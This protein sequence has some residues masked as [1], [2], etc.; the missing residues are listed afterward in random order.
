MNRPSQNSNRIAIIGTIPPPFGGVSIHI[1]R[2]LALLERANIGFTVY[3]QSCKDD[4]N[5]NIVPFKPSV[6]SFLKLLWRMPERLVHFH[7][8]RLPVLAVAAWVLRFRRKNYIFTIHS[9][10]PLRVIR[11]ANVITRLAYKNC[12][13]NASHIICVSS[14]IEEFMLS[15]G[16]PQSRTAV[17]PAFLPPTEKET[18]PTNIP[19]EVN[20]FLERYNKTVGTHGWFG[21]FIDG[22]HVYSFDHVVELAKH[23][24][25][26]HPDVGL[27]T[28][29]SGTYEESHRDQI[30]ELR[31]AAQLEDN[32]MIIE[33][34]FVA[35]ALYK[36]TDVFIRPTIT[37]GDSVSIR[38]CLFLDTPVV[39]SDAV[40]RPKG[41]HIFPNRDFDAMLKLT[42][43]A[44]NSSAKPSA[45]TT[46][47][48]FENRLIQILEHN[49]KTTYS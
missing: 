42:I 49:V 45:L 6:F 44:L 43:E 18:C 22:V 10:Q 48:G 2:K 16:V 14:T 33:S 24:K 13:R 29:I 26:N 34:Q 41:C 25:A 12:L 20:R 37:D 36:K 3:E 8:N 40:K 30:F 46:A 15:I 35:A 27:Y 19:E 38:E 32:W 39:A 7:T 23:L 28:I 31:K 21:Y 1:E 17:I 9:E 5:R 47:D 4:P 11:G